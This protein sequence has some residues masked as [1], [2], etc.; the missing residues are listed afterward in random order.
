M[1]SLVLA[2]CLFSLLRSLTGDPSFAFAKSVCLD[3]VNR[4]FTFYISRALP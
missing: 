4:L 2:F 1:A 3:F